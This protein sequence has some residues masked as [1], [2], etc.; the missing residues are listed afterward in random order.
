[1]LKD[2]GTIKWT[3]MMLTEHVQLLKQWDTEERYI[4]KPH[5]TA[6]ELDDLQQTIEQAIR[7]HL[8][9]EITIWSNGETSSYVGFIKKLNIERQEL[10]FETSTDIKKLSIVA[11]VAARLLDDC[12]D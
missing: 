6:W 1:M 12:Y 7:T 10:Y 8:Q 9:L 3:S 11:I 5:L 2:R 4:E